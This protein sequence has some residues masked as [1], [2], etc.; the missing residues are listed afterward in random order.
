MSGSLGAIGIHKA[1]GSV[2]PLGPLSMV[3]GQKWIYEKAAT[4][5]EW[6]VK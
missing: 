3:N 2:S 1:L 5:Q 4:N 6:R